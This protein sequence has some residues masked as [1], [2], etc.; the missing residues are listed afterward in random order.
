[1]TS[2]TD[3]ELSSVLRISV[4]R[5]SR[6]MRQERS[7]EAGLSATQLAAMATLRRHGPLTAGEL[8]SHEKVSPPSMTRVLSRLSDLGMVDRRSSPRDGRQVLV[9]LSQAGERLL[10]ADRRRRDE[11]LAERLRELTPAERDQL[12]GVVGLLDRLAGG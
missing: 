1:V 6:R 7:G 3:L 2:P 11:W 4:M 10:A 5:L 12:R 9:E 8:A